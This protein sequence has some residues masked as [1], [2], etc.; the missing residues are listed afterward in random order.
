[1]ENPN[2]EVTEQ[3]LVKEEPTKLDNKELLELKAQLDALTSE[4]EEAINQLNEVK[5]R[6]MTAEEWQ[7][8]KKK[9]NEEAKNYRL[10]AKEL[11]KQL[12]EM[13]KQNEER[14]VSLKESLVKGLDGESKRIAL[15][16]PISEIPNYIATIKAKVTSQGAENPANVNISQGAKNFTELQNNPFTS[17]NKFI[18]QV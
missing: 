18:N 1:M 15:L 9:L 11:R 6:S 13:K 5:E 8:H 17:R 4:K 14:E 7:E 3:P 12:E 10:E 2:N 16:L